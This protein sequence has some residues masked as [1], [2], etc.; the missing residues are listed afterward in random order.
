[1]KSTI[2]PVAAPLSVAG[3]EAD[4]IAPPGAAA[5]LEVAVGEAPVPS[6]GKQPMKARAIEIIKQRIKRGIYKP[7]ERLPSIRALSSELDI[8]ARVIQRAVEQ[9]EGESIIEKRHGVGMTIL[10]SADCQSTSLWFGFVQPYFSRYSMALQSYLEDALDKQRNL[11]VMKSSRNDAAREREEIEHLIASGV[12]GLLIYPVNADTNGPFLQ[13]VA[14]R[15]PV[16]IVDR[17]LPD[18]SVPTVVYDCLKGGRQIVRHLNKTGRP[19]ILMI[20]D[21]V[22]IS[23]YVQLKRGMREEAELLGI[24]DSLTIMDYPVIALIENAYKEDYTV[25]DG[26]YH[27]LL[28]LFQSG[29][30]DAVFCPQSDFFDQVFSDGE[31]AKALSGM[32]GVTLRGPDGPPHSRHYR[33]LGIDEWIYDPAQMLVTALE[34]LQ[35]M[36]LRRTDWHRNIRLNFTLREAGK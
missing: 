11:C 28:P 1:M 22:E 13:E 23:S 33:S 5:M 16:V 12:D 18:V 26:C 25:A 2:P 15:L 17:T 4:S 14:Q 6:R 29:E 8:S 3:P 27:S 30:Y 10:D 9:L 36:T 7:G 20:C 34:I 31:R 21:P 24:T 19:R 35:D 32:Q